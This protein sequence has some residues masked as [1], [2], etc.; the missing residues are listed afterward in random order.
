MKNYLTTID[1]ASLQDT[2]F[3]TE[4]NVSLAETTTWGKNRGCSFVTGTCLLTGGREFCSS[5]GTS[6]CD[7]QY[8]KKADCV[9][10]F[11]N[12]C[13]HLRPVINSSSSR[14]DCTDPN[15]IPVHS[16]LITG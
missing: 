7:F 15:Y 14:Y 16:T 13:N 6:A 5:L 2:G 4:V 12:D 9:S 3:Y 10:A 1:I 11:N 8:L